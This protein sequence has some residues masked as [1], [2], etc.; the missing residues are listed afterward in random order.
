[1]G[2]VEFEHVGLRY[3]LSDELVCS[4][5][6]GSAV[7][8]LYATSVMRS[9]LS[10]GRPILATRIRGAFSDIDGG[11][12]GAPTIL[13]SEL[14][15]RIGRMVA[16]G[17]MVLMVFA[18]ISI[19]PMLENACYPVW[20]NEITAD[21]LR[22]IMPRAGT[23]ADVFAPLLNT[24]MAAFEITTLQRQAAF[25]AQLAE[26]SGDLSAVEEDLRYSAARMVELRPAQ[27]PTLAVAQ[28]Y[29]GKPVAFAN[30]YYA[31]MNGNGDEASGDGYRFRGRGLIQLTGRAEYTK[32]GYDS[33]PDALLKPET[34]AESA[35]KYWFNKNLRRTNGKTSLNAATSDI[36]ARDA[37]DQVSMSVNGG[38]HK[39]NERWAAYQRALRAMNIVPLF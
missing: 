2:T 1:M 10:G 7:S 36:L 3:R 5:P 9:A 6:L 17:R 27:F 22:A 14:P 13:P 38:R 33:D 29:V 35:A 21:Q 23:R 19:G 31:G 12:A 8:S 39:I 30:R 25:L 32:L 16:Q 26:E 4:V 34:A 15:N 24:A 20:P 28:Q 11:R 18:P 37:F